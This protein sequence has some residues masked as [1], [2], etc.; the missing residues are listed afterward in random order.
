MHVVDK[1][2]F[3]ELQLRSSEATKDDVLLALPRTRNE[4]T[5]DNPRAELNSAQCCKVKFCPY[6]AVVC[7]TS[8]KQ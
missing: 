8:I 6:V 5:L 1:A 4:P 3:C 7:T 2:S